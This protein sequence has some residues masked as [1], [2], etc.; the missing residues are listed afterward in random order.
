METLY[1]E[2]FEPGRRFKTAGKT[3]S[4]AEILEFALKYDPQP[5]HMDAEAAKA[6]IYGGLIASG[7]QTLAVTLRLAVQHG[8]LSDSSLGSPGIEELRWF[9]PVRPGDTLHTEV[10]VLEVRPSQS[11][12]DRGVVILKWDCVNQAGETVMTFRSPQMVKARA[13]P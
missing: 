4:E 3:V 2:D 13:R 8:I 10:E 9:K 5:F 6:T 1:F 12:P 11:K 7:I